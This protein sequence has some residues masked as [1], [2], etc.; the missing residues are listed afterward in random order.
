M[1]KVQ[2]GPPGDK[3]FILGSYASSLKIPGFR[4]AFAFKC[5]ILQQNLS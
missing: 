1:E 4:L 2:K 3:K 5:W